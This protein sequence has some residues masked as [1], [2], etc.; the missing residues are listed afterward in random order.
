VG[1]GLAIG[2][3]AA[4]ATGHLIASQLFDVRPWDPRLL[5]GAALL[6]GLAALI[7]AMIP[8]RQATTVDPMVAL[9]C[10]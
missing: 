10:E 5:S 6:L 8:A 9:R 4:I 3:P 2:M 7:A 1:I